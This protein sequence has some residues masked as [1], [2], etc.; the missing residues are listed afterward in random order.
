MD[1]NNVLQ[2]II[3]V[4]PPIV[5]MI[6]GVVESFAPNM[7]NLVLLGVSL[8]GGWLISQNELTKTAMWLVSSGLIFALL[9][10]A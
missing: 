5:E 1:I 10:Y 8:V 4:L 6:R 9:V 7:G 2:M 3:D